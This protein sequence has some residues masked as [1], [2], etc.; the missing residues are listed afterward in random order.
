MSRFAHAVPILLCFMIWRAGFAYG[1]QG[2]GKLKQLQL[3]DTTITSA[4]S[5][6][7]GPFELPPGAPSKSVE[8]PAF[9]R[10]QAEIRP[11]RDS[12]IKMEVWMP[13][14]EWNGKFEQVGNGG[15]G[16]SI[17]LF[18]LAGVLRNG[19]VA[20]ATDDGHQGAPT[21]GSWA[22]G[23]PEKVKDFG[24]RA[25][26]Q[27]DVKAKKIIEAFYQKKPRYSYFNGCSEGG[28]EALMEAQRF[29]GDFN[30]I[31]AGAPA[32]YWTSLMAA[33]DW[34]AQALN[35]TGTFIPDAKRRL[36]QRAAVASCGRQDRVS[37]NFIQDPEHCS[38]DPSMLLCNG[39]DSDSCLTAAQVNAL[40]KIYSGP[41]N[42][43]T[44]QQISAGYEP[45]AEAEPGLPG[46]SFESYIFGAGPGASLDSMFSSAFYSSF[47]FEKRDWKFA[48]LNFDN[49]IAETDAKVGSILNASDPDLSGFQAHGGKLL[50]YHGW[51]DGSPP[52]R[53]STDYYEHV[54]EKMGGFEKTHQFYLLFMAP[55]MMHCGQGEGPNVFGNLLDFMPARDAGRNIFLA[56]EQWVEHGKAPSEIV[57]TKY[58][59]NDPGKGV[60]MT[61]PLCPYPEQA[62][63]I[64][65]GSDSI[66]SNW[67]CQLSAH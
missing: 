66:A 5:V 24:Y 62:T 22:M 4:Q 31:L 52:P 15:L 55:G 50:Q 53:H 37:D 57:A 17:N 33:F 21:D 40:K 19:F 20:A 61:R 47:V 16:G 10:V 3:A 28:R 46:I 13:A 48:D 34:N 64:G 9:C 1:Q 49:D 56:L 26:H 6:P 44:K 58:R 35:T 29:P 36:I 60:E 41:K 45:G 25:V 65:K 43:R 30:G 38:F 67:V 8:L 12:R 2:C 18:V 23:H 63:L 7:A 32:H 27:T 11:S 39:A 59:D 14:S 54:A 42:P 51:N